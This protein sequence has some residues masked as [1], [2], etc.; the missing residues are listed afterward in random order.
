MGEIEETPKQGEIEETP[1]QKPQAKTP[2]AKT[3]APTKELNALV[4]FDDN[5]LLFNGDGKG[6][7]DIGP[8]LAP[9]V[10]RFDVPTAL[11]L[12]FVLSDAPLGGTPPGLSCFDVEFPTVPWA[13]ENLT[14]TGVVIGARHGGL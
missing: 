3:L 5:V 8:L 7:S 4:D 12:D 13:S 1:Y 9:R 10:R 2:Q 11:D 6:I 14:L